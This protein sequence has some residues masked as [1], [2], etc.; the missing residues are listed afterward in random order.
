MSY[1]VAADAGSSWLA[2]KLVALATTGTG[3][4]VDIAIGAGALGQAVL[5]TYR[6]G[7][8]RKNR[9]RIAAGVVGALVLMLLVAAR[10]HS[11]DISTRTAVLFAAALLPILALSRLAAEWFVR[12]A[13]RHGVAR[14]RTLVIG[15]DEDA[16]RVIEYFRRNG[17]RSLHIIGHLAPVKAHAVAA[18]G[19]TQEL[20][21]MIEQHDVEHVIVAGGVSGA[22]YFRIARESLLRGATVGVI[23]GVIDEELPIATFR[24]VAGWPALQLRVGRLDMICVAVKR[25]VDVVASLV[26]IALMAIPLLVIALLVRLDSPGPVFFRQRRPGLGGRTFY[27]LKFRSMRADAEAILHGDEALYA[28]FVENGCKLPEG[29]DPRI[30]RLGQ[31]LRRSSLDELPQL[32]NV[33][34]GDMSLVGPR[35]VVGPE[36]EHF[37]DRAAVILSVKPGMTGLWQ[38]SGRS[39]VGPVDRAVLD[40]EYVANWSLGLDF[41]ILVRTVPAVFRRVGA[42]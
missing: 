35:P 6:A 24:S 29:E 16:W 41:R 22:S 20:P 27:M 7:S 40:M 2:W 37:G 3:H 36:L 33:L 10:S 39:T 21:A 14:K 11:V 5:G 13:H 28:R 12:V 19:S 23:D 26:L 30:S 8:F 18:L 9:D 32:F 1:L 31:L 42:H 38:V 34:V 17:E 15:S 25:L 4:H